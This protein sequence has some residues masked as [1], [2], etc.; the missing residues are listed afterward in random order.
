MRQQGQPRVVNA[1]PTHEEETTAESRALASMGT[2]GLT[3]TE[4]RYQTAVVVQVPRDMDRLAERV[5]KEAT[6]A[7]DDFFYAFTVKGKDP[8]TGEYVPSVIEGPSIDGAMIML[9]NW[10]N[11][12]CDPELIEEGPTHWVFSATFIDLETGFTSTRLFRQ[13][14][15]EKHGKFDAERAMDIAF[16]I[17]QS[18]AIRNVVIR[19]LPAWLVARAMDAA[20]LACE[21]DYENVKDAL[22]RIFSGFARLGVNQEQLEKKVGRAAEH[23]LPR[24]CV[25]LRAIFKAI[26]DRQTTPQDEFPIEAPQ[27]PQ[28]GV[29]SQQAGQAA[30]TPGAGASTSPSYENRSDP[31]VGGVAVGPAPA[32]VRPDPAPAA[33]AQGAPPA[34]PPAQVDQ[35]GQATIPGAAPAASA[36]K[37]KGKAAA[38]AEAPTEPAKRTREPGED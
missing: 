8:R 4:T 33:A 11:A 18:K 3:R 15:G 38:Q 5:Y 27:E 23:W 36:T 30:P 25:L 1:P 13:R 32:E 16:Q 34:T 35:A 2:R 28:P 12:V 19:S 24:D 6:I 7:R 22:P 10:G 21:K 17:G 9:R 26:N 29:A 20:K 31:F 14:K 37:T